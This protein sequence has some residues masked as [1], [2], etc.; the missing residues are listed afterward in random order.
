MTVKKMNLRSCGKKVNYL[1]SK[2]KGDSVV[3][4]HNFKRQALID[5]FSK[6]SIDLV[7]QEATRSN[8]KY[9]IAYL[10]RFCV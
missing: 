7:L 3:I 2:D 1:P 4:C 5:G 10:S 6:N 8:K 9:M